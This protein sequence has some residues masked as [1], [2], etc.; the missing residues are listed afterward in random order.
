MARPRRSSRP[1]SRT[2][3]RVLQRDGYRCQWC[4]ARATVVDHV[5]PR[6]LGGSDHDPRNLVASCVPCNQRR[7]ARLMVELGYGNPRPCVGGRRIRPGAIGGGVA[8]P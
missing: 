3:L 7:A 1:W 2:R 4:G 5:V 6:A 8:S